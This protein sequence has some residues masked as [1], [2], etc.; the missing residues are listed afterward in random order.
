MANGVPGGKEESAGLERGSQ[1]FVTIHQHA[2][3]PVLPFYVMLSFVTCVGAKSACGTPPT[4]RQ[5]ETKR[6]LAF[7]LLLLLTATSDD[8]LS[9]TSLVY[10]DMRIP[11]SGCS[12][13]GRLNDSE[14]VRVS[15]LDADA[16]LCR[17]LTQKISLFIVSYSSLDT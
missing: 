3:Q 14:K 17:P 6:L 7:F 11:G 8:K 9:T 13:G 4:R 16:A 10:I 15:I 2:S 1:R 12:L 5:R